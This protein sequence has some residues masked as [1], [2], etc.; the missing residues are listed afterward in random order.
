MKIESANR[1][2]RPLLKLKDPWAK[3]GL[4]TGVDLLFVGVIG[5]L[6]VII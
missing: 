2:N 3:V 1:L 5:E 6:K 4:T